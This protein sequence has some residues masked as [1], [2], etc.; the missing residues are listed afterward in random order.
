MEK[1]FLNSTKDGAVFNT[2]P[3]IFIMLVPALSCP[4]NTSMPTTAGLLALNV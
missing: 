1:Q 4:L 3:S 2:V